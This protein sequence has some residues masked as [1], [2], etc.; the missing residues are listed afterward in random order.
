M[1]FWTALTLGAGALHLLLKKETSRRIALNAIGPVW[2][3]NEVWLVIGGGVLFAGFPVAYAAIFSAFYVPFMI[4]LVGLIWR[5]VAI[6]FQEQGTGH[7]LAVYQG[8]GVFL[9]L[10]C[11][12][13][14]TGPNVGEC[15][16]GHSVK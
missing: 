13:L 3:G 15:G 8:C 7:Y 10:Y 1:Q 14:I 6:E 11:N 12:R 5:A 9:L 4:F 2:D 16:I